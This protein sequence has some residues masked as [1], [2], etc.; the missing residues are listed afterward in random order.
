MNTALR[1]FIRVF[2][3]F[4][5]LFPSPLPTGAEAFTDWVRDVR[6]TY[7]LPTEDE[8]SI[9]FSFATMI[10]HAGPTAASKP[11]YFFVLA[12]RA[13]A[14]KQVAGAAFYD[15][16]KKQEAANEAQHKAE[17]TAIDAVADGPTN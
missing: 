14:A 15:I 13:A 12:L 11:K 16:K 2:K 6:S 10:M 8:N 3:Q 4:R 9:I 17:A 5:G 1:K 7:D